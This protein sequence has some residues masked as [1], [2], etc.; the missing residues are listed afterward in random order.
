MCLCLLCHWPSVWGKVLRGTFYGL[1]QHRIPGKTA[2]ISLLLGDPD[3]ET[4]VIKQRYYN[5]SQN[6]FSVIPSAQ[7]EIFPDSHRGCQLK[8]ST[9][10]S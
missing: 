2:P 1:S 10:P 3:Y 4:S 7:L 6:Q 8:V 9:V 5:D